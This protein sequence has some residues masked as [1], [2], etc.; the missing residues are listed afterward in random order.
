MTSIRINLIGYDALVGSGILDQAGSWNGKTPKAVIVTQKSVAA[1]ASQLADAIPAKAEIVELPDGEAAKDL[2]VIRSL[3]QNALDAGI[4]RTDAVYAVGGGGVGDAAGFFAATYLRG[5]PLVQVPT[6]LLAQVDSS[7]GGKVGVNF[8]HAKNMVGAF[9]LPKLVVSDV[10]TLATLP[11][12]Q[13]TNGLAEVIKY[14]LILDESFL[15]DVDAHLDGL[16]SKKTEILTHVVQTCVQYKGKIVAE[17]EKEKGVRMKL[18]YGHTV[19]H[20]IESLTGMAHG[21]AISAGMAAAGRIAA[22]KG[23]LAEN[24]REQ[25]DALLEKAGL[26]LTAKADADAVMDKMRLDKKRAGGKIR[27]VLLDKLGSC[28]IQDV[29]E[30]E[31]RKALE[32]VL[33]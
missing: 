27:M 30:D 1:Y 32:D 3:Y 13:V 10:D 16:Y 21:H 9:Y 22:Q 6:T 28:R 24:N 12:N 4:E 20:A 19:G 29:N 26:P 31:V 15:S 17:D 5:L 33:A 14:G 23:L 18:N 7:I 8:G 11:K 2:D 25:Q